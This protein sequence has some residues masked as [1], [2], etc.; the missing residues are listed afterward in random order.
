MPSGALENLTTT[1]CK[2][3]DKENTDRPGVRYFAYA[4]CGLTNIFLKPSHAYLQHVG[5]TA[6]EKQND[7]MV[8]IASA[9]HNGLTEPP[10]E[11]ADHVTEVGWQLNR[12]GFK[13]EFDHAGAI[14]RIVHRL[15]AIG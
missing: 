8:T 3:F 14:A 7:G 9:A 6:E 2:A 4:G 12:L 15:E 5:Q 10:W 11:G 1:F 13:S